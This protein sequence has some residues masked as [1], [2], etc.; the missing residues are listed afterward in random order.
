MSRQPPFDVAL[1]DRLPGV[2]AI[3]LHE[4]VVADLPELRLH[5]LCDAFE[6]ITRFCTALAVAEVRLLVEAPNLPEQLVKGLGPS[7]LTPTFARWLG[8]AKELADFLARDRSNPVVLP[9]LPRFIRGV[10]L[11]AAPRDQRYLEASL[12]E[13]RNTLAHGGR[14]TGDMAEYLLHGDTSGLGQGLLPPVPPEVDAEE[15][16]E[17]GPPVPAGEG[18]PP[19]SWTF[20]GWEA[21]LGEAVTGLASLLDGCR[22]CSFDGE[23]ARDL[24]GLQPSGAVVPLS[25]DLRLTLRGLQLRGHVLLLGGGRWLD[26][27]PLCA[28][29]KARLMSLRGLIESDDEAPLLYYRGERRRLL[30]A[31]F[32]TNPPVSESEDAVA[33]FQALFQTERRQETASQV[34][35]DF[36]EELRSDARQMIGRAAEFQHV[37][38]VLDQ[39]PSGVLWLEGTGGVGKSFLTAKV[40]VK[41]GTDPRRWC[42]I[43]WRFRLSD[44]DRGNLNAFLRHAVT[45]LAAW[46][47][48]GRAGVR[49]DLDSGKLPA[50]L[51]ELLRA[52]GQLRP[53]GKGVPPPRVLF[54]LDGMDEAARL[55]PELL[56]WPFRVP[57]DNVV[58]LCAGRPGEATSKVFAPGPC[59]H[60]FPGGLPPMSRGDVRAL[61]YQRLG[62]QKYE[63]LGL[64][65]R[66]ESGDVTN[67][68]VEAIIARSEGLPLYVHF[69]VADLL[70]GH[71][72]L[73]RH[74]KSKLPQG[75]AAY[76][77][78]L[79]TR[80]QIDDVQALL[81]KLLGTIVWAQ[82]PVAASVLFELLRRLENERPEKW[83][84]LRADVEQGLQRA[85]NLVRPGSLPEGEPAYLPCHTTFQDHFRASPRLG[86][87]NDQARDSFVRLTT[88]WRDITEPAAR[89]Y[90]F[91]HGP[92][93]LLDRGRH[94]EL[95]ALA[96][97][98]AF[99]QAQAEELPGEPDAPLWTLQA[100]LTAAG[101]RDDAAGTAEFLLRHARHTHALQNESP[102]GALRHG[103]LGRALRLADLADSMRAVVHHLL[104]A[105]ELLDQDRVEPARQ[106]LDQLARRTLP[107]LDGESSAFH[108]NLYS[109]DGPSYGPAAVESFARIGRLLPAPVADLAL[110]LLGNSELVQLVEVLIG[111]GLLGLARSLTEGGT[112]G[113]QRSRLLA[114]LA[115]ATQAQ[116]GQAPQTPQAFEYPDDLSEELRE[117]LA[118]PV[119]RKPF[120][121]EHALQT[122]Q[123]IEEPRQRC[124]ALQKIARGQ[125]W[126]GQAAAARLTFEQALQAAHA[127][128]D[129]SGR[130]EALRDIAAAQVGAG[131]AE[132]ALRTASA[133]E[134]ADHRSRVLCAIAES[135]A[136]GG[137]A[138]AALRTASAIE[139]PDHRSR[140]LRDIAAAYSEA[141]RPE[142]ARLALEQ[143]LQAARAI[144]HPYSRSVALWDV[145]A[146][147]AQAVR[148]KAASP[149]LEEALQ[150]A[151][152]IED[153]SWQSLALQSIAAAQA[154]AGRPSAAR[155]TFEHALQTA[156]AIEEPEHRS[157]ALQH[158]AEAQ[159]QAG[160]AEAARLA[161]EQAIRTAHAI[162]KPYPRSAALGGIAA[163]QAKA[164][165]AEAACRTFGQALQT[166]HALDGP[167]HR[168][169]ALQGIAAAQAQAG[170]AEASRLH[171]EQ[172]LQTAHAIEVPSR[173]SLALGGLAAAQAQAGQAEAAR[174]SFEQSLQSAQ[175]TEDPE[176]RLRALQDVAR[177]LVFA[178]TQGQALP[179]IL[180]EAVDALAAVWGEQNFNEHDRAEGLRE[181]AS[182]QAGLGMSEQAVATAR[183][184]L[185]DRQEHL[186]AIVGSFLEAG[187][188]TGF[189][190]LLIPCAAYLQSAW[191]VCGL[192]AQA[193]PQ[194]ASA[195]AQVALLFGRDPAS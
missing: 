92:Q 28:H 113:V 133:I 59:R 154:E 162:D 169:W 138:E 97:D 58:W 111:E 114:K 71:F 158:I 22:V 8:L 101:R 195:I 185:V 122:A 119:A 171:V 54:V 72:E 96:R 76:Y 69:L 27:W 176:Q 103:N 168:S 31:A 14:L 186:P 100:A 126:A 86:R 65:R 3:P 94:E 183:S 42:C 51:D 43:P 11:T 177:E 35:P 152:A 62:E 9:G 194:Q 147:Q 12:L 151:L 191:V 190:E 30:Y 121:F 170:Q 74:L 159:A 5:R 115:A 78:D 193:Y 125:A 70:T 108:L 116:A 166:A 188:R 104:L 130:S 57:Y 26:L 33:G 106:V 21:V 160:Q 110:R 83:D 161:F 48:L 13:M 95:V 117:M 29:D 139:A 136:R 142:A 175:A 82:G 172:A 179:D 34:A 155:L 41:R 107:A 99:L 24:T 145:A 79:L 143:A 73:T 173:R 132:A 157:R 87:T 56:E 137:E 88:D 105:W 17:E 140:A 120:S 84:R 16:N 189:K 23:T 124:E 50:Q 64:D 90:V 150:T 192:L 6:I 109:P 118:T 128:E 45:C 61:L 146:A 91:R 52:A 164:G 4:F 123:A 25:A 89:R 148:G 44:T 2:L 55:G 10:L 149:S 32:G 85:A 77:E 102:L 127:V 182:I 112:G 53:A 134:D 180:K 131:Q 141:G 174:L 47:P 7:I 49:P 135:Q 129:T 163:A 15:A 20:R 67:P 167:E 93:H 98:A 38:K 1:L 19:G 75:L 181:V 81:P 46:K 40:A 60:L 156:L 144:E 66:D 184:M 63:L 178:G 37:L 39:T 153:P 68:L 18:P 80:A 36:T 165:Q 187:D